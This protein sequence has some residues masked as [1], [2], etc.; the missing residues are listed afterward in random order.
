MRANDGVGCLTPHRAGRQSW[1]R[2]HGT[3]G[4][5]PWA[6]SPSSWPRFLIDVTGKSLD[7]DDSVAS[8]DDLSHV[9]NRLLLLWGTGLLLFP[10]GGVTP[11][12]PDLELGHLAEGRRDPDRAAP[13]VDRRPTSVDP[14]DS[15]QA[16]RVV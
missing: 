16:V 15:T 11:R 2:H 12:L 4:P 14:Y 3:D 13:E 7:L 5:I 9:V 8:W 6:R 10:D 1:W